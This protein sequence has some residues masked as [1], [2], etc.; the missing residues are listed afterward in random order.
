MLT[1]D[2]CREQAEECVSLAD[3]DP[4]NKDRWLDMAKAWLRLA[5]EADQL[6]E[7]VKRS[8]DS[9]QDKFPN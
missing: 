3:R 1:G 9:K 5:V 6:K 8:N 7:F 2:E 4:P